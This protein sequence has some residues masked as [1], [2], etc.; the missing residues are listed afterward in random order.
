MNTKFSDAILKRKRQGFI[1][2][3]PDIKRISPKEGEMLK[4]RDAVE[5]VKKLIEAGAPALS[6]VTEDKYFGGS[7]ALLKKVSEAAE[8]IPVLQK[9]FIISADQLKS[10]KDNG[11][12]AVLLI[13]AIQNF[14]MI[15]KLYK[16][17]IELDL[18]P[19]IEIHTMEELSSAL[20]IGAKL[21]GINNR[22]IVGLEK[23]DGTIDLTR[24][25]AGCIPDNVTVISES[26]IKTP[27][28]AKEAIIAGADAVL[29]GTA[30]WQADDM[31]G[32]YKSLSS[33]ID[34]KIKTIR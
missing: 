30:I 7:M 14:S 12:D 34:F 28:E 1:P 31:I 18:E 23:D 3:I 9:D 20:E 17:A 2:V 15:K 13:C 29:V 4:G 8:T 19:L 10:A 5:I 22:D 6:V 24:K 21:I 33:R 32:F 25:L 16:K 11:A 27:G 26:S